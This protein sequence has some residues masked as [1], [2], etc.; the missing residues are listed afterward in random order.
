MPKKQRQDPELVRQ[1]LALQHELDKVDRLGGKLSV[2][3]DQTLAVL[4]TEDLQ[5]GVMAERT[6]TTRQVLAAMQSERARVG[7]P[8]ELVVT[9]PVGIPI[10]RRTSYTVKQIMGQAHHRVLIFGFAI[11]K[12]F[13]ALVED[14]LHRGVRLDVVVDRAMN[15]DLTLKAHDNLRLWRPAEEER[16]M[17]AKVIVID[18]GTPGACALVGSANFTKSGLGN[19]GPSSKHNWEMGVLCGRATA[20]QIWTVFSEHLLTKQSTGPW[21][22]PWS[23]ARTK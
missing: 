10:G 7:R 18:P 13:C 23:P 11:R 14:A 3:G 22:H 15:A 4:A 6:W 5:S 19:P 12:Q 21:L 17:H 2:K 8:P 20:D 16:L 1:V 9:L